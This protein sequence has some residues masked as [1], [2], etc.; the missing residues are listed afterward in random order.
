MKLSRA[1]TRIFYAV[2]A[3]LLFGAVLGVGKLLRPAH[4]QFA[5]IDDWYTG[6]P[7]S[8]DWTELEPGRI[9]AVSR[10][11]SPGAGAHLVDKDW[12]EITRED[13]EMLS[14]SP[15]PETGKLHAV[16]MRGLQLSRYHHQISAQVSADRGVWI[17]TQTVSHW[18]LPM[19]QRPVI[20]FL[21]V[22]PL[23]VYVDALVLDNVR[24][25][26]EEDPDDPVASVDEQGSGQEPRSN[27]APSPKP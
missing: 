16:L 10:M 13:A 8:G 19:L 5:K 12:V 4:K 6:A 15:L 17:K 1:Q 11:L 21:S 14:E 22:L 25:G 24:P 26:D 9:F 3:L 7:D 18:P 2:F 27:D 20:V 23:K